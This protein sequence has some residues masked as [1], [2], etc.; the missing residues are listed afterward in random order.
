MIISISLLV[1]LI[2][3]CFSFVFGV[4][5]YKVSYGEYKKYLNILLNL[6]LL[7]LIIVI[8]SL[9]VCFIYIIPYTPD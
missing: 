6:D 5:L 8:I 4:V 1:L 2:K 3:V 7:K 9:Y